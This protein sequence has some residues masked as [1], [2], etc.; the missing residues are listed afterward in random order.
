ML[1]MI[2]LLIV[3]VD[4]SSVIHPFKTVSVNNFILIIRLF[5]IYILILLVL[6]LVLVLLVL[7]SSCQ[8]N[9]KLILFTPRSFKPV[10]AVIPLT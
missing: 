10:S 9:L 2:Y 1:L 7:V 4:L 3:I 8:F 6:I 5:V